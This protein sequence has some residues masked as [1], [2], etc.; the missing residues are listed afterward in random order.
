MSSGAVLTKEQV[1]KWRDDP[2]QYRNRGMVLPEEW[3]AL[4]DLALASLEERQA[5]ERVEK[6]LR[7]LVRLRDERDKIDAVD[8]KGWTR[9][10]SR[11][12]GKSTMD[13]RAAWEAARSALSGEQ[14]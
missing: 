13:M 14:T 2:A 5:R 8:A 11:L 4:C 7:E 10:Q 1:E 12:L 9:E 3:R 6:A